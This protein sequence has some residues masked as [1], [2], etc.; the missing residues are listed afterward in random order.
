MYYTLYNSTNT[1]QPK[2]AS[3]TAIA[4][5]FTEL[6]L[7]LAVVY[8]SIV[9]DFFLGY[10]LSKKVKNEIPGSTASGKLESSKW[11]HTIVKVRDASLVLGLAYIFDLF[12]L[13]SENFYLSRLAAGFI[14]GAELLSV[15]EN[16]AYLYP[17]A[18][19]LR[20][21]VKNKIEKHLDIDIDEA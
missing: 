13:Q 17:W 14:A 21:Y 8:L 11:W 9:I 18:K 16:L 3:L 4:A 19:F 6:Y 2:V 5:L 7:L 15:V 10:T 20:K 12:I 1:L